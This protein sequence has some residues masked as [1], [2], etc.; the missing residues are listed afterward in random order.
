MPCNARVAALTG[1][2][3]D[4][5]PRVQ[6]SAGGPNFSWNHLELIALTARS[7]LLCG[8]RRKA[9]KR[10]C[11]DGRERSA[12]TESPNTVPSSPTRRNFS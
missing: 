6:R 3:E 4:M 1:C 10:G 12:C 5:E 8:G 7:G 9:A 2:R 11:A